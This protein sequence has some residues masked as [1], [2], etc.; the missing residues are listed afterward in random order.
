ML[1]GDG[2]SLC[3][4]ID[5]VDVGIDPVDSVET[6][7]VEAHDVASWIPPRERS[8]HKWNQS[9]RVLAGSLGMGG[10]ASLVSAA[11]MRA[12]AGIVHL[13]WRGRDAVIPRRKL[14]VV[15]FPKLVGH[16]L[17]RRILTDSIH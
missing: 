8:A 15:R 14:L 3:G 13:S 9:V 17:L 12:G 10:A 5:V 7:I 4:E 11:A 2:P 16:H 1:F 6:Y